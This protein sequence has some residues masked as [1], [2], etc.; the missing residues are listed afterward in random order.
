MVQF[1]MSVCS[2]LPQLAEGTGLRHLKYIF[3]Y[4]ASR[5]VQKMVEGAAL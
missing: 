4:L 1:L 3:F 2:L 5:G